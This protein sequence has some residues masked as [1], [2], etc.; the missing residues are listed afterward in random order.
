[1]GK[2]QIYGLMTG[3]ASNIRLSVTRYMLSTVPRQAALINAGVTEVDFTKPFQTFQLF[4][5]LAQIFELIEC[6]LG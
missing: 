3:H 6:R 5:L 4:H 1:M 2:V